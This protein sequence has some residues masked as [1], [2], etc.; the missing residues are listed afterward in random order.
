MKILKAGINLPVLTK[1]FLKYTGKGKCFMDA[2]ICKYLDLYG[3]ILGIETMVSEKEKD[4]FF[5]FTHS[6]THSDDDRGIWNTDK[7]LG[8]GPVVDE[9]KV[10]LAG[11]HQLS[12]CLGNIKTVLCTWVFR[13]LYF[14][15][16]LSFNST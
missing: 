1:L 2:Y 3:Q 12:I 5:C 11:Q 15:I 7:V 4:S 14:N 10:Q 9:L 6:F 16:N 8:K 13:N